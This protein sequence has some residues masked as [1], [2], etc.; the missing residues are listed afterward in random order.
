MVFSTNVENYN[1]RR[2]FSKLLKFDPALNRPWF[3][4][5]YDQQGRRR[6]LTE[7]IHTTTASPQ[8]SKSG[9]AVT[10][11]V[12]ATIMLSVISFMLETLPIMA[13]YSEECQQCKPLTRTEK[14][15]AELVERRRNATESCSGC[16]PGVKPVFGDIEIICIVIFTL[17]YFVRVCTAFSVRF[18]KNLVHFV[19]NN[20]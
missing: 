10:L 19:C 18:V 14:L 3:V 15:N 20:V 17:E 1:A 4:S 12:V 9:S 5:K 2:H 13:E 16:E 6:T 8:L 7:Q 11:F